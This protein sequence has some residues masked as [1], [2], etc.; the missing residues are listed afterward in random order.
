MA[1]GEQRFEAVI[2]GGNHVSPAQIIRL[3]IPSVQHTLFR[4]S[5]VTGQRQVGPVFSRV[6]DTIAGLSL[7]Q[8][9]CSQFHH[10]MVIGVPMLCA[11]S[12]SYVRHIPQDLKEQIT[13]TNEPKLSRRR[14]RFVNPKD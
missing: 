9:A 1:S 8:P 6:V 11:M 7:T 13:T 5:I 3:S 12:S 14:L 2:A 10:G 4:L